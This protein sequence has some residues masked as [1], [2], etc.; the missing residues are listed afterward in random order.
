MNRRIA[1]A[2]IAVLVLVVIA[3]LV[4]REEGSDDEEVAAVNSTEAP[5][6]TTSVPPETEPA[7]AATEEDE[8]TTTSQAV[9]T[10]T[11]TT[12]TA[13]PAT[14]TTTAPPPPIEDRLPRTEAEASE[15]DPVPLGEVIEAAPGLWDIAITEV[16]LDAAEVVLG[17]A[18]INPEPA[19]G[20]RYVL[21][22]IEGTYLGGSVAQP[23]FEWA[24]T[25]GEVEYRPSI[26]GCGFVP[27]SIYDV[28]EVVPGES[29]RA[30]VCMPVDETDIGSGLELFL[31]AP[32]DEPK[33]FSLG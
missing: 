33:Y 21:V 16:N 32:G 3:A 18:D 13:A 22:T 31:N 1:I 26:P 10:E 17:F 8:Q 14:T 24:I 23:V 28:V 30:R 5:S 19:A 7:P 2:A 15:D 12:T 29:F 6:V 4:T 9:V 20:V 11:T 25:A 27:D